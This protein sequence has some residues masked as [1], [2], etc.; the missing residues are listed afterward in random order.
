[1]ALEDHPPAGPRGRTGASAEAAAAAYLTAHGWTVLARNV[2][3]GRDEL[4]LVACSPA[5]EH[6]LVAVEVRARTGSA[7]GSGLESVD[8]PKVARLYRATAA[9]RRCGHPS[10]GPG[11]LRRPLRVDLLSLRRAGSGAWVVEVHLRGLEPPG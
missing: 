10:L 7:F 11:P 1:M 2:R 9:L 5:P 6:E 3:I 8:G 4:D